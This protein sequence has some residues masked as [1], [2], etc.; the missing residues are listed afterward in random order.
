MR[1]ANGIGSVYKLS[2]NRR[3]PY[4][5]RKTTG[6]EIDE[7]SGKAKQKYITIGYAPTRAKGL[8]MLLDYNKN[9]FG[10]E[11]SKITFAE[12]FSK[13]SAEKFP[14][15]SDSN[16]K[17]YNA[18]YNCCSAIH[19][20]VFKDLKLTDLQGMI[21]TCGK[22]YPTL[23]KL[24]VLLSQMYEYAMKYEYCNKDYSQYVDILYKNRNP[25]RTTAVHSALRKSKRSGC[26]RIIY[27]HR[28][29]SC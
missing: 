7:E 16:V 8:E 14:T 18:S 15:I 23:R 24:K 20:R 6:W 2:G 10:V 13:W 22:N 21:D 25:N 4:I 19:D 11:S 29:S 17:G 9:P 26:R 27:T 28:S 3:N 1:L 12:I 5:V